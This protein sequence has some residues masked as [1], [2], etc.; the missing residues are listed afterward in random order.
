MVHSF[1]ILKVPR[2]TKDLPTG[3]LSVYYPSIVSQLHPF[4]CFHLITPS[5]TRSPHF[6]VL[7][8]ILYGLAPIQ[9]SK[10]DLHFLSNPS[11]SMYSNIIRLM[12]LQTNHDTVVEEDC[13]ILAHLL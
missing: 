10:R 8:I 12:V 9:R 11:H 7:P 3:F 2:L 6:S 5:Y 1:S 4:L 13:V